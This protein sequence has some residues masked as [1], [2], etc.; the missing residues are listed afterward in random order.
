MKC[1][2]CGYVSKYIESRYIVSEGSFFSNGQS[3]PEKYKGFSHVPCCDKCG[4]PSND[5]LDLSIEEFF[6]LIKDNSERKVSGKAL[7]RYFELD[8][9]LSSQSKGGDEP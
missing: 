4:E 5:Y 9:L 6:N 2:K 3:I 8:K 1:K 7:I